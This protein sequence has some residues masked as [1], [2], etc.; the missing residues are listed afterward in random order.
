MQS[1][2][3]PFFDNRPSAP[4]MLGIGK[5]DPVSENR[6]SCEGWFNYL[7]I[8]LL[9][10]L[11]FS[12][13]LSFS[14]DI[15]V[16]SLAPVSEVVVVA[17]MKQWGVSSHVHPFEAMY[18]C[19]SDDGTCRGISNS[20]LVDSVYEHIARQMSNVSVW[21]GDP[22]QWRISSPEN[23][24]VTWPATVSPSDVAGAVEIK[25]GQT[26]KPLCLALG[27]PYTLKIQARNKAG[28]LVCVGGDYLEA[29]LMGPRVKARPFTQDHGDGTYSV[30]VLLPDDE[31]LV[32]P[33]ELSVGHLFTGL[34]G[35][36]WNHHWEVG[37]SKTALAVPRTH[38]RFERW[39]GC[40]GVQKMGYKADDSPPLPAPTVSCRSLDFMSQPFW[41]GHWV[42]QPTEDEVCSPGACTGRPNGTLTLPWV[43][44]LPHCFF[45]LFPPLEARKCLNNSWIFSSGD[46]TMLDT[47]GNL[48]VSTLRL[49]TE[50]WVDMPA[51]LPR[52][53]HFDATGEHKAWNSSTGTSLQPPSDS[54]GWGHEKGED[55]NGGR[56]EAFFGRFSNIWNAATQ[57]SGALHDQ[58][59]QGFT[60]VH[61]KGWQGRHNALISPWASAGMGPDIIMVNSGMHDGMRFSLDY[62]SFRDYRIYAD[63]SA[64]KWWETLRDISSPPDSHGNCLPR[65]IWRHTMAPAGSHRTKRSNPQH[66]E[67]FNRMVFMAIKAWDWKK[68]GDLSSQGVGVKAPFKEELLVPRRPPPATRRATPSPNNCKRPQQGFATNWDF[69]DA[70]D[71]TFPWH[72][73]DSVSDGGHYGRHMFPGTDNVDKVIIQT[74][75]NGLCPA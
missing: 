64:P 56:E 37:S 53:R 4:L 8:A 51:A 59:C 31:L 14:P 25:S 70:F 66:M 62:N 11:L 1:I 16:L 15:E 47:L 42:K 19:P 46:S 2:S 55:G 57:T 72:F 40:G 39:G 65:M 32:G 28:E 36:A 71:M 68:G 7:K 63:D 58:C 44:R 60:V 38:I 34:A 3:I 73:D 52:G 12:S 13:L 43:Y 45:H 18:S 49:P 29:Q 30:T 41:R 35:L 23:F 75:L 5:S 61:D 9:L 48:M 54:W 24:N 74:L 26:P 67:V 6:R 10:M 17:P 27:M 33:A 20:F 22:C 50:G 21:G 69:I